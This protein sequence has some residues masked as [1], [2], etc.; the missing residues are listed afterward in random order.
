MEILNGAQT[1][2]IIIVPAAGIETR[3]YIPIMLYITTHFVKGTAEEEREWNLSYSPSTI[4]D[5][6]GNNNTAKF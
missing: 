5:L 6:I 1:T 2:T 4:P 3:R